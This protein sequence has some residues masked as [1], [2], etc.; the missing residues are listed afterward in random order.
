MLISLKKPY[1]NFSNSMHFRVAQ[2][3]KH[4]LPGALESLSAYGCKSNK[5][6]FF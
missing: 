5:K 3:S 6:S 2:G 1:L 4:P